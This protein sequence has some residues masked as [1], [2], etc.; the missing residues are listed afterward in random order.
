MED[1]AIYQTNP[2]S[3]TELLTLMANTNTQIDIFSDSIIQAVKN[4]ELDPF[5]V[6]VHDRANKKA[7]ERI[8]NEIKSELQNA[9]EKHPGKS[10][11][12]MGN[13]IEKAEHGTK[14]DYSNCGYSEWNKF[15]KEIEN[16]TE[17]LKECE[18]FLKALRGPIEILNSDT[19][20]VE[21]VS[22]PTKKSTSGFNVKLK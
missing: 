5:T 12:Y 1:Q 11:E 3:P 9:A 13:V 18:T 7:F 4:G 17:K 15:S 20:E 19:G 21:I 22:P 14:Y 16:L 6:L 8:L 2:N 10:F